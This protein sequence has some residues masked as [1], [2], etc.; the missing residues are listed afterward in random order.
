M[1]F[2]ALL[3]MNRREAKWTKESRPSLTPSSVTHYYKNSHAIYDPSFRYPEP[4]GD[5]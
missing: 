3:E 5:S 4:G 1:F 2:I